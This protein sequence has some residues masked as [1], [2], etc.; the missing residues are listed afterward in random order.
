MI[1]IRLPDEMLARVDEERR[2]AGLTRAAA[3]NEA[4]ELW[5][6]RRRYEEAVR[7]D[8]EGYEKHPVK[9]EEFGSVL[10]AQVWPK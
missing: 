9:E 7:R 4:L 8:H 6:E 2:R 5:I 3:V 1:A 10:G